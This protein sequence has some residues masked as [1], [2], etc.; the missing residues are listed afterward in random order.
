MRVMVAR[1]RML[2]FLLPIISSI[3]LNPSS[4]YCDLEKQ[5][6]TDSDVNGRIE[7]LFTEKNI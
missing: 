3:S 2:Y 1:E 7:N 6:M 5:V 4:Y